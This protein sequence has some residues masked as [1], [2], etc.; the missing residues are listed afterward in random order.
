MAF[1]RSR[2]GKRE[3]LGIPPTLK[4]IITLL[5]LLPS[6]NR[7]KAVLGVLGIA[8][9]SLLPIAVAMATGLLIGSIPGALADGSTSP[10]SQHLVSLVVVMGCLVLTQQMVTPVLTALGETLGREVDRHLQ[11]RVLTAVGRPASA[12]RTT[13]S[14]AW[15]SAR[16]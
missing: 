1:A 15:P 12:S 14:R 3:K 2:W 11:E 10:A 7:S 4:G 9:V 8:L 13:T 5:R 6:V 16:W